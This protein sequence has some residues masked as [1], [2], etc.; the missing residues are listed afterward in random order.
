LAQ[1]VSL[2]V[3]TCDT[4]AVPEC[5]RAVG[6]KLSPE[7][8][9]AT[10]YLPSPT[11]QETR[12]NLLV[13]GRIALL[14]SYPLDHR[15]L[16]LKGAVTRVELADPSALP[17]VQSYVDRFASVLEVVGMPPDLVRMISHWPAFAVDFSIEE[18]FVQTPGP[19]AGAPL[20]GA[21][22]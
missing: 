4:N 18:L 15:S 2:L 14:A 21:S 16:Q 1:G 9:R 11:S 20:S 5:M 3:A 7:R 12:S 13:N 17:F 10:V 19:G 6:L 22:L 8:D